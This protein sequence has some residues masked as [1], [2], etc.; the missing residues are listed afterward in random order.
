MDHIVIKVIIGIILLG[1]L[2]A[3]RASF[4]RIICQRKKADRIEQE[5]G[6]DTREEYSDEIRKNIASYY[7]GNPEEGQIDD[8]TWNDLDM[9]AVFALVNHTRTS[10]GEEYLYYLLRTPQFDHAPLD[11]REKL[12]QSFLTH[13]EER[14]EFEMLLYDIG[15]TDKISVFELL[16][17]TKELKKIKRYPHVAAACVMLGTLLS[18][19]LSPASAFLLLFAVMGV[20]SYF[21]YREKAKIIQNISLFHFILGIIKQSE[22]L[23]KIRLPGCETYF[24]RLRELSGRFQKFCRFRFLV[25]AGDGIFA[26]AFDSLFDYIRILFHVDLIKFG[27]MINEVQKYQAEL[28]EIYRL[29][30]YLESMLAV[31]SFRAR[32]PQHAVPVL[33]RRQR[34]GLR[35]ENLYHPLVNNPVK[36]TM[37]TEKSVLITGSNAS[38]KST[39]LK[40]LAVNAIFAQ[41]IH[42]V[43]ADCFTGS[44]SRIYSSM[45]LRDNIVAQE[46]YFIVEIK[47]LK[48]IFNAIS[49]EEEENRR[50]TADG[51]RGDPFDEKGRDAAEGDGRDPLDE[52][53]RDAAEG[54]GRDPLDEKGRDTADGDRGLAEN[55]TK[56]W[57]D[58]PVLCFIDEILRGTNTVERIAASSQL[59]QEI[60]KGRALCF[61]A[62]HDIELTRLLEESFENYHFEEVLS[63]GDILFDYTLKNGRATSRNAISLLEL[64]GFDKKVTDRARR[65]VDTFLEEGV[66][67]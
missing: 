43:L 15:K 6:I 40:A 1:I 36:N 41:T 56:K 25:Y 2:F 62:T 53:G 3:V 20:N 48:R 27:T 37:D 38:G 45:A 49:F 21:Y 33:E 60:A 16:S 47:S 18:L 29:T 66:W 46:S 14:M 4:D 8:I 34:P 39:F 50:D 32:Y 24:E 52:K 17:G 26:A 30:G 64:I 12:I 11:E 35:A 10:P 7:R 5:W 61:A 63:D 55:G 67:K 59:L 31:S 13:P 9:D 51:D 58:V 19:P 22:K 44:F 54:D 57:L 23:G 65:R 28:M 42:T